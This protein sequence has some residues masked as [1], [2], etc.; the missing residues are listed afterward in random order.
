MIPIPFTS[1]RPTPGFDNDLEGNSSNMTGFTPSALSNG[2]AR[3]DFNYTQHGLKCGQKEDPM[4]HI[5]RMLAE[6]YLTI[7]ITV[8]GV[9]G[10]LLSLVLLCYHRRFQKLHTILIQLQALAIVDTLILVNGL[11]L[12]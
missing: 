5:A 3:S 2:C 1:H 4:V 12:R 10:N 7:P 9:I 11:L 8:L 6:V